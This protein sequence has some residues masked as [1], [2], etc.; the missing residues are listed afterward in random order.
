MAEQPVILGFDPGRQKCGVAV[1]GVDR[2]IYY[3]QVISS[4]ETISTISSLRSQFPISLLVMGD[5]TSSKTWRQKLETDLSEPMRIITVDERNSSLEAR[6]RYW[7]MYPPKGLT[8]L[9]PEGMRT[10]PRPID[11]IVAILLIER[12]LGRLVSGGVGE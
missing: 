12:Y 8:R 11:D 3:H 5:Q 2:R 6:D 7:Q 1:M 4:E 9:I 10:P